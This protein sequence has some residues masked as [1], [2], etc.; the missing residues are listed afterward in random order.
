MIYIL[1]DPVD[2]E[3]QET[4]DAECRSITALAKPTETAT[5]INISG[6][7]ENHQIETESF[8]GRLTQVFRRPGESPQ[9]QQN[10]VAKFIGNDY[11][12]LVVEDESPTP[13][14]AERIGAGQKSGHREIATYTS[15]RESAGHL[16]A[17]EVAELLQRTLNEDR[18]AK[19]AL[20]GLAEQVNEI[21]APGRLRNDCSQIC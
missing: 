2:H 9:R 5:S 18:P 4:L 13:D 6:I 15:L 11:Q 12:A 10:I 8:V 16:G 17:T 19:K 14:D 7:L 1:C 20:T 3:L 21:A